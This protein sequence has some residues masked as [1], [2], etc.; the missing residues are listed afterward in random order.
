[1]SMPI[2][3][4]VILALGMGML[5]IFGALASVIAWRGRSTAGPSHYPTKQGVGRITLFPLNPRQLFD[6]HDHALGARQM[7]CASGLEAGLAHPLD[8]AVCAV[9]RRRKQ[10]RPGLLWVLTLV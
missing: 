7:L 8:S 6:A 2:T 5:L 3:P 10:T 1:M 9:W 4:M